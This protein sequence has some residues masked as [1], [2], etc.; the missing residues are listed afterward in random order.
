MLAEKNMNEEYKTNDDITTFLKKKQDVRYR[1]RELAQENRANDPSLICATILG[2]QLH[3]EWQKAIK[4]FWEHQ[5][6]LED[7][8]R[9]ATWEECKAH[10]I[11]W[12]IKNKNNPAT[13]KSMGI[14]N[15]AIEKFKE[16]ASEIAANQAATIAQQETIEN[17]RT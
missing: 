4:K 8:G 2:L 16:Q 1:L 12:E 11:K 15:T 7:N 10:I 13:K 6:A 9:E 17:L 5:E 3:A 14:A